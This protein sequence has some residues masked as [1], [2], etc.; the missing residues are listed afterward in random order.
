MQAGPR[1]DA[2]KVI[3]RGIR[4]HGG[5]TALTKAQAGTR[6]CLGS[7][8]VGAES[9]PF[10]QVQEF[11][12]PDK[13]RLKVDLQK[14][15]TTLSVVNGKQGWFLAGGTMSEMGAAVKEEVR[16]D[17]RIWYLTTLTPLRKEPYELKPV[18]DARVDGKVVSGVK[19]SSADQRDVILYFDNDS[20]KLIKVAAKVRFGGMIVDKEYL[21][22]G[23]KEF[24]GAL[25]PTQVVEMIDGRKYTEAKECTYVLRKPDESLFTKP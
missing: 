9:V 17:L 21:L 6:K 16:Q 19:V 5:E 20:G 3:E 10:T 2:L 1:E 22:S 12:Y 11:S 7:V 18:T 25:L 8:V 14:R 15:G 23:H 24:D 13:Q 4:A